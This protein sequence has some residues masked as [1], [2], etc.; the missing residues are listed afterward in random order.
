MR[1]IIPRIHNPNPMTLKLTKPPIPAT[2]PSNTTKN[3]KKD[4]NP[5]NPQRKIKMP[6]QSA[7]KDSP[8]NTRSI[9]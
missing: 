9:N 6:N 4:K 3:T 1:N 8:A 5:L 7:R 2:F